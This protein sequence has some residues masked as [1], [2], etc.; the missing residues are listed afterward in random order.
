MNKT[1]FFTFHAVK[2]RIW[3]WINGTCN[4]VTLKQFIE[5]PDELAFNIEGSCKDY[6]IKSGKVH[7]VG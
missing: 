6:Q 3:L 4:R 1:D 5:L 7:V 2:G